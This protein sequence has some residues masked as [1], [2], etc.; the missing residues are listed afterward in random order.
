[1]TTIRPS[2]RCRVCHYRLDPVLTASG[3]DTHPACDPHVKPR[4][5]SGRFTSEG[6]AA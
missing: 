5:T 6:R 2:H 4:P 1:M 3:H